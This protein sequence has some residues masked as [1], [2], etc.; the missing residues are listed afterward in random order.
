MLRNSLKI[1][2]KIFFIISV[3]PVVFFLKYIYTFDYKYW[4]NFHFDSV[5]VWAI[6]VEHVPGWYSNKFNPFNDY[7]LQI[8]AFLMFALYYVLSLWCFTQVTRRILNNLKINNIPISQLFVINFLLS[9]LVFGMISRIAIFFPIWV[10]AYIFI[11]IVIILS[12]KDSIYNLKALKLFNFNAEIKSLCGIIV[13]FIFN[14]VWNIQ[15]GRNFLVPDSNTTFLELQK[16]FYNSE[17][18]APVVNKQTDELYF[19][20]IPSHFLG[21]NKFALSYL[22]TIALFKTSFTIFIYVFAKSLLRNSALTFLYLASIFFGSN[23]IFSQFY[24]SLV[25]GQ[26]PLLYLG[27]PGRYYS[28]I[29][30]ILFIRYLYLNNSD[31]LL[32]NKKIRFIFWFLVLLLP[33]TYSNVTFLLFLSL[34]TVLQHVKSV[35]ILNIAIS[36]SWVLI[37]FQLIDIFGKSNF[38]FSAYLLVFIFVL[39]LLLFYTSLPNLNLFS[40]LKGLIVVLLVSFLTGNIWLQLLNIDLMKMYDFIN[41]NVYEYGNRNVKFGLL[42]DSLCFNPPTPMCSDLTSFLA[43]NSTILIV[44]YISLILILFNKLTD[45]KFE[46]TVYLYI[47]ITFAFSIFLL[48]FTGIQDLGF[49][50]VQTR[51]MEISFYTSFLLLLLI[52]KKLSKLK[53]T[54]WFFSFCLWILVSILSHSIIQQ[55]ILNTTYLFDHIPQL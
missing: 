51:F 54:I 35:K 38:N 9:Y 7:D 2:S 18:I 33:T 16:T 29:V 28:L 53:R 24:S 20:L 41:L 3:L 10:T 4:N 26:N 21:E 44:L 48:F 50:W 31:K 37:T 19:N 30:F 43:Y 25:G 40:I 11:V 15:S 13:V 8:F 34:F 14:F 42:S 55:F 45:F 52:I 17:S 32:D 1:K 27:H 22:V 12:Y 47:I 46:M 6:A 39:M 23:I 36:G 49:Y 5:Q